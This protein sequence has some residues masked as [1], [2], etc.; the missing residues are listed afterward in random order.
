MKKFTLTLTVAL[1]V[2]GCATNFTTRTDPD[3]TKTTQRTIT[4]VGM[5]N[6]S[7]NETIVI[8]GDIEMRSGANQE[9]RIT[10]EQ[11]AALINFMTD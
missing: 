7:Q 11:A 5:G 8:D 6:D 4:T 10:P 2:S 1:L 3:G 9:N